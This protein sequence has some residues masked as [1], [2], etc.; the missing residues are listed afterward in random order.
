MRTL[1]TGNWILN[2]FYARN[3]IPEQMPTHQEIVHSLK[4]RNSK[5]EARRKV[6]RSFIVGE[7]WCDDSELSRGYDRP[8][9]VLEPGGEVIPRRKLNVPMYVAALYRGC[10]ISHLA[11]GTTIRSCDN[12][13]SLKY[14]TDEPA[15]RCREIRATSV[16]YCG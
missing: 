7:A 6:S 11:S 10:T 4:K 13:V 1:Y 8:D 15:S 5:R 16:G 9:R 14:A 2:I 12:R 3:P